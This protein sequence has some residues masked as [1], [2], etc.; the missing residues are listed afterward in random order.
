MQLRLYQQAAVDSV[1]QHLRTRDDNPCV[2]IPTGGGKT[3]IIA[4]LC[5]DA[6]DQ[7]GGR[8]LVLAHVKELLE[9]SAATL[10]RFAPNLRVGVYSA[11]LK[12]RDTC[13]PIIVAGIQSIFKRAC[14]LDAFDL[15]IVDEA[16]LLPPDGE[17]MYQTFLS[18]A[19]IVN[20]YIRL[21]GLTATPYRLKSGMLCGPENLLNHVCFEVG[22]KELIVNGYLCPLKT[23][24]GRRKAETSSLH[25]RGGEFVGSEVEAMM[26]TDELVSAAC[27]EIAMATRD[28]KSVL[29]FAASVTHAQHVQTAIKTTTGAE[30][31]L[32]T[33]DTLPSVR[34]ELIARFKGE[35]IP[36]NLFGDTKPQL[37]FLVNVNVL[38]TGFD[39]PNV[40]C[41][42]LLRP[43]ASPGL[44]YQMVGRGFRLHADK[45][46]CLVLDYGDNII[47]HGPVD[48]I[49]IKQRTGS[50]G[51]E[52]AKECPKCQSV[53][54]AAY[55]ICPD[56]GFPFPPPERNKHGT[57]A[58]DEGILSG[59]VTE[60]EYEVQDVSYSVHIKRDAPED[61]P[62]TMRVDYR[63]GLDHWQSEWICIEHTGFVL[64]KAKAWW[65]ERSPDPFPDS[66]QR[67]VEIA[68]GG[69]LAF[70]RMITVR[71]VAGEKYDRIVRCELGELPESVQL[72]EAIEFDE[73]EVP[74]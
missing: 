72:D 69:G 1:Y 52:P 64:Q 59:E 16:H 46:D 28:R 24:A 5:R 43:T 26:D 2:V 21:I 47:R 54:H 29:I 37:K 39:A 8:V 11:G 20:P 14:E 18:D 48:A 40:D 58:S 53:V 22:V 32:I 34:D 42:V 60:T 30:C 23:K 57:R 55:T 17:G 12:R 13:E 36:A 62:R 56:C 50:G 3:P 73:S 66:S 49:E 6:V 10:R 27:R 15:I 33:G 35:H 38:T 31:G 19:R 67:A 51:D 41:V 25:I 71:S 7:W 4:Q 70:P 68:L 74:F 61:A 45:T 65:R 63:I 9:Q 44:Y